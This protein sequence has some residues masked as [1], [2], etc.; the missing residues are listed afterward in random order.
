MQAQATRMGKIIL[1]ATHC[2]R[3]VRRGT[4]PDQDL[5]NLVAEDIS[6]LLTCLICSPALV[7]WLLR[8]SD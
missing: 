6:P 1:C 8:N 3:F 7:N 2:E 5:L 4:R